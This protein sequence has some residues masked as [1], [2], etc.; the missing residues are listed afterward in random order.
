[1]WPNSP[2]SPVETTSHCTPK[3]GSS[4]FRRTEQDLQSLFSHTE[5]GWKSASY[6]GPALPELHACEVQVQ[7]AD[8]ERH[9][10]TDTTRRLVCHDGSESH[11][12]SHVKC[13]ET[14]ES[15]SGS[16]L[17]AK[18]KQRFQVFPFNLALAPRTFTKCMDAALALLR[19]QD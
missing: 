2:W 4:S 13:S 16:L 1:M 10:I 11:L 12:F 7:D 19:F 5:E 6:S 14:Q 18:W 9:S 8:V 3:G 17:G 15:S